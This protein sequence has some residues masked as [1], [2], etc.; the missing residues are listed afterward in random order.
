MRFRFGQ[1]PIIANFKICN[2]GT[3]LYPKRTLMTHFEFSMRFT[4]STRMTVDEDVNINHQSWQHSL[5][6]Q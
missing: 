4:N 1:S 5:L 3:G 6:L 2:V